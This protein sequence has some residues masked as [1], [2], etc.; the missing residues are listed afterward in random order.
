MKRANYIGAPEFFC[1]NGACRIVEEAFN[2]S[3]GTYLVGSSLHKR[4]YRDVDVR[5]ILPDV[6]YDRLFP[7][8]F[9]SDWR[10]PLWSF[11]CSSMSLYL[12]RHSGLKIDFQIQRMTEAN[13][14]YPSPE[15]ERCAIGQFVYRAPPK[16]TPE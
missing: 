8:K 4:D 7:E 16:E 6:E 3:H 13:A 12:S 1:L 10:H 11:M 2:F 5:T 15:H 9:G 14:E